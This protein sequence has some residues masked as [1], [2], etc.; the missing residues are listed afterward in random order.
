VSEA[1]FHWQ[2]DPDPA[3]WDAVIANSPQGNLFCER[4]FLD[5]ADVEYGLYLIRQGAHTKAGVCVVKGP[6]GNSCMLDDLVIYN[7]LLFLP[8]AQK[9]PVRRR[10][11]QFGLTEFA[12]EQLTNLFETVELALAPQIEDLR[13]FSW[14]NYHNPDPATRFSLNLRYTTYVDISDLARGGKPEES[15]VFCAM[16]TLRQRH[17]REAGRKAGVVRRAVG[18]ALL[19]AYYR[20]LM[21]RQG[22]KPPEEKLARME[23]LID[24]LV[25]A[26]RGAVFE[27]LNQSGH[28]VYLVAYGWDSRRAY[29]LFGAGHPDISEPW[30]G[31]V[32]HWAAFKDMACRYGIAEVD[33]EG[34]NSPRR[35]WFKLGFGGSLVPYYQVTK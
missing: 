17:I 7:G 8:D 1:K 2:P 10:F 35:G 28:V 18:C 20:A 3:E 33:M 9:K 27:V 31:T 15:E 23:H 14:H 19:I 32:A 11:E 4:L 24:G 30:Q 26:N 12:I 21:L 13:P 16:E 22:E 25:A 5:L 29:Y 34:V 6:G